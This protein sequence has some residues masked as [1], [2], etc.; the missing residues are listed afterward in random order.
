MVLNIRIG[1]G[2]GSVVAAAF[3]SL[4]GSAASS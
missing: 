2:N 3:S 1:R 4:R